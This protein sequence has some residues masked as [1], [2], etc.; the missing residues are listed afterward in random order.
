MPWSDADIKQRP[1][2]AACTDQA[3]MPLL[4]SLHDALPAQSLRPNVQLPKDFKSPSG[5]CATHQVKL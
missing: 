5:A 4:W 3:S 1:H 2:N